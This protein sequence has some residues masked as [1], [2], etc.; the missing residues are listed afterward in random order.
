MRVNK[1]F[2]YSRRETEGACWDRQR[3]HVDDWLIAE[4]ARL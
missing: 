3:K 1:R 4:K 2:E